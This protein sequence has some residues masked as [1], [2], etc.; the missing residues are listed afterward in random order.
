MLAIETDEFGHRGYDEYDEEIRYDDVF[1]HHSGNWIW[2]RFNPDPT[3]YDKT[4]LKDRI[5]K[6]IVTIRECI[7]KIEREAK[8]VNE[9]DNEEKIVEIIKLY[10]SDEVK[11]N[12]PVEDILA[13]EMDEKE[14]LIED[15]SAE[16]IDLSAPNAGEILQNRISLLEDL[17][18]NHVGP[19]Q[20]NSNQE[21]VYEEIIHDEFSHSNGKPPLSEPEDEALNQE[22]L[23]P[24]KRI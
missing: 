22:D 7:E 6:L 19:N 2:I 14:S 17:L 15:L 23:R 13:N 21:I 8:E 9:F 18:S 11:E 16:Q 3:R 4:P 24:I 10:Y 20:M 12:I 1:M 5:A